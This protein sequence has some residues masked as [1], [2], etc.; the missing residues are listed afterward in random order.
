MALLTLN[1]GLYTGA[2]AKRE[3]TYSDG[4]TG[5]EVRADVYVR[6]Y[7]IA[8]ARKWMQG[9]KDGDDYQL[10]QVI[11]D[12]ICDEDGTPLFAVEDVLRFKQDLIFSLLDAI[13][14]VNNPK[15]TAT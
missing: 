9:G 11:A 3:I 14:E 13:G 4:N 1:D 2:P 15:P 10:A 8:Q 12:N 7:G 6:Q 5:A